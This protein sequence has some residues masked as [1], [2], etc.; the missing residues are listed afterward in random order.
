M[1]LIK[2]ILYVLIV[3]LLPFFVKADHIYGGEIIVNCIDTNNGVYQIDLF[4]RRKCSNTLMPSQLPI[5]VQTCQSSNTTLVTEYIGANFIPSTCSQDNN[6]LNISNLQSFEIVNYRTTALLGKNCGL[7]NISYLAPSSRVFNSNLLNTFSD[8]YI[9]AVINSNFPLISSIVKPLNVYAASSDQKFIDIFSMLSKNSDSISVELSAPYLGQGSNVLN[10]ILAN[11][12]SGLN[13]KKLFYI[14]DS[15]IE[16]NKN[17]WS[18]TPILPQNGYVNFVVKEFKKSNSNQFQLIHQRNI[19]EYLILNNT[20]NFS[21]LLEVNSAKSNLK[22]IDSNS[23]IS[24]SY[25]TKDTISFKFLL[26]KNLTQ[27]KLKNRLFYENSVFKPIDSFILFGALF[28]T[29]TYSYLLNSYNEKEINKFVF[30]ITTCQ[31]NQEFYKSIEVNLHHFEEEI[32]FND[33]IISCQNDSVY[34]IP[35]KNSKSVSIKMDNFSIF[36]S[37]KLTFDFIN[38]KSTYLYA[39][40]STINPFCKTKDTLIFIQ[41]TP[42]KDSLNIQNVSCFGYTDGKVKLNLTGGNAPYIIKWL[43]SNS[44][45]SDSIENLKKGSYELEVKD[46]NQCIKNIKFNILEPSGIV[47]QWNTTMPIRCFGDSN[48]QGHFSIHSNRL[49]TNYIWNHFTHQDSFLNNLKAG[50]YS[51]QFLYKNIN[52]LNCSQPF[53]VKIVEPNPI[54]F[55][56]FIK[57][58]Q[59]YGDSN[60]IIAVN[61]NGGNGFY[62]YFLDN[63]LFILSTINNLKTGIYDLKVKDITNCFSENKS[64]VVSSPSKISSKIVQSN[65]YC[66]EVSN[67]KIEIR[68]STGGNGQYLYSIDSFPFGHNTL[69]QNLQSKPVLKISTKDSRGCI[70]DTFINFSPFYKLKA[71]LFLKDTLKCYNDQS[72]ILDLE[73]FNGFQPYYFD[74][75]SISYRLTAKKTLIQ[76]INAGTFDIKI[77]DSFGCRWDSI[78][79]ISAPDSL[80]IFEEIKS[81]T[82]IQDENGSVKIKLNGGVPPYKNINWNQSPTTSLDFN[83]LKSGNYILSFQDA[84]NCLFSKK[85]IVPNTET[86]HYTYEWIQKPSCIDDSSGVINLNFNGKK[87]ERVYWQNVLLHSNKINKIKYHKSYQIQ[88]ID[89]NG[90]QSFDSIRLEK[91][92]YIKSELLKIK[93]P[94]CNEKSDGIVSLD[95]SPDSLNKYNLSFSMDNFVSSQ[96]SPIFFNLSTNITSLYIKDTFQCI[97]ILPLKLAPLRELKVKVK[98]DRGVVNPGEIID[99]SAQIDFINTTNSSDIITKYWTSINRVD[100]DTCIETSSQVIKKSFYAYNILYGNQCFAS[101]TIFVDINPIQEIYIPN[102][103]SIKSNSGNSCWKVFG[104]FIK[105]METKVF[106]ELG[107]CIFQSNKKDF[108][109]NGT[110]KNRMVVGNT[111]YYQISV[112]YIDEVK[113]HYAGE[114]FILK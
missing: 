10:P 109:W 95:I 21:Y 89:S 99:L 70:S 87:P 103:F 24:C 107:E 59:C 47:A 17:F 88:L 52:G 25:Q 50:L 5:N 100:C 93:N 66:E 53:E 54:D 48:A 67:G 104:H 16:V 29:L 6:C 65:P 42:I 41:S 56:T 84:N 37:N 80:F 14:K 97:T 11:L 101:D 34:N 96:K 77:R 75:S 108:C 111:F 83:N 73:L 23:W 1:I 64:V 61:A 49:P 94:S 20:S 22:K 44:F 81:P 78:V 58:N 82:C 60:G 55:T 26:P 19:E 43:N 36:Q 9:H 79:I 92:N 33:S 98:Q 39:N 3:S 38:P 112:T 32:F 46:I 4:I 85:I 62:T 69:F 110:F 74:F 35:L 86:I 106:N 27:F 105:N 40:Y 51:G 68:S 113:K 102:A 71:K 31:N 18:F 30:D 45:L 63:K 57:D 72:G 28:D 114:L 13:S 15:I 7:L 90:C 12:K 76:N 2:R 8:F 91:D